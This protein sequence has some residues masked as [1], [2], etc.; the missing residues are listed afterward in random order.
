MTAPPQNLDPRS[1]Y[2]GVTAGQLAD[3]AT[4]EQAPPGT[5]QSMWK[6]PGACGT[7]VLCGRVAAF[8]L[9]VGGDGNAWQRSIFFSSMTRRPPLSFFFPASPLS[10]RPPPPLSPTITHTDCGESSY[11]G[12]GRLVDRVALVTGGDSGIGR[13]VA[14]AFAREGADIAC[15][16]WKQEEMEDAREVEALVKDAGRKCVLVCADLATETGVATAIDATVAALGR[17]IDIAVLNAGYQH[18]AASKSWTDISAADIDRTLATN[19]KGSLLLA[20][21]VVGHMDAGEFSF[22][23]GGV[24]GRSIA[25]G[26]G[27]G[28]IAADFS[29]FPFSTLFLPFP[30][31]RGPA[32]IF[33]SSIQGAE[34][35][36]AIL[37]YAATKAALINLSNCLAQDLA[38]LGIRV[39]C[40]C[41]GPVWTPLVVQSFGSTPG[42]LAAF[43]KNDAP[44][45]RAAQ[46]AE[47]APTYVY[48]ADARAA[49]FVSGA[50]IAVTGGRAL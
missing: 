47:L 34:P 39:N 7:C 44:L 21:K 5:Q 43:G 3:T 24:G 48:L 46:P 45:G 33:T 40:V 35:S 36:P 26:R 12:A 9:G 6:K 11:V 16:F 8:F 31:A 38:K 49:S 29:F 28:S 50:V 32:I 17:T 37:D 41:P 27:A 25:V 13:A 15:C 10:P 1:M 4:A 30:A 14:I 42:K 19:V 20:Q 22:F 2:A 23:L 18:V